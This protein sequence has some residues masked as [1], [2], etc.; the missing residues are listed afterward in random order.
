MGYARKATKGNKVATSPHFGRILQAY[1]DLL[2]RDGR[3]IDK[4]FYEDVV[5]GLIPNY[6]LMAWYQFIRKFRSPST[7]KLEVNTV[8]LLPSPAN[9][10][11]EIMAKKDE[12]QGTILSNQQATQLGIQAA[13][14]LGGQALKELFENPQLL[15]PEKRA[16][17]MFKAMKAQD[18]RIHAIGKVREDDREQKKFDRAFDNAAY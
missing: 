17:L 14:N 6:S 1:N 5:A 8:A 11:T 13:L 18:S 16:E 9:T 2:V 7:G 3:V 15:T 12:L 10:T 4:K